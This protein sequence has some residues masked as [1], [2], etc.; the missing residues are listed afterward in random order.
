MAQ[1]AWNVSQKWLGGMGRR[2]QT[3][4]RGFR[5]IN[6]KELGAVFVSQV[7]LVQTSELPAKNVTTKTSKQEN[8]RF[9]VAIIRKMDFTPI[10]GI[11]QGEIRSRGA[12]GKRL[13]PDDEMGGH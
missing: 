8:D 10:H 11:A 6:E 2:Q 1:S 13:C 5:N 4:V 3:F 7:E 9:L 12:N